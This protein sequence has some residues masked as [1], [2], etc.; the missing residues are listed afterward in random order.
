MKHRS[1]IFALIFFL[2]HSA[3]ATEQILEKVS[4]GKGEFVFLQE[5]LSQLLS[6]EEFNQRYYVEPACSAAWRGYRGHW[7]IAD[8]E[9]YLMNL[10]RDPCGGQIDSRDWE[11]KQFDLGKIREG[12]RAHSKPILADWYTGEIVIPIGDTEVVTPDEDAID[13]YQYWFE[14]V[15][16]RI[17][18]GQVVNRTIEKRQD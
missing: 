12:A 11:A 18:K 16:Y 9:L 15:V 14:A 13:P 1:I 7:L 3:E 2:Q 6:A 5:P 4:V 8:E 10:E 17:E